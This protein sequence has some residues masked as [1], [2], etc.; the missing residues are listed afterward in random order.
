SEMHLAVDHPWQYV[1]PRK[2]Q[3]TVCTPAGP[4]ITK[5]HNPALYT[6][7]VDALGTV[8]CEH[9][10]ATEQQIGMTQIRLLGRLCGSGGRNLRGF[11]RHGFAFATSA[12]R[13]SCAVKRIRSI[14]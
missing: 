12:S 11:W 2:V 6:G 3:H 10:A 5:S 9:R 4:Q 13:A 8:R 1:Q 14:M 7:D